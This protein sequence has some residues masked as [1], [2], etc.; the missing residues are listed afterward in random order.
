VPEGYVTNIPATLMPSGEV[1][2]SHHDLW[3]RAGRRAADTG[4]LP[5][6]CL[7]NGHPSRVP[8]PLSRSRDAS[9][10]GRSARRPSQQSPSP[11]AR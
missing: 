5:I 8:R 1:I 11:S 6:L 10:P 7:A 2:D 4:P 3:D 9:S